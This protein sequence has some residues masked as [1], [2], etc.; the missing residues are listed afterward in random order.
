MKGTH[1]LST[2]LPLW[3]AIR[4]TAITA[5]TTGLL[6]A[7]A[8]TPAVPESSFTIQDWL[9][10]G[11][12]AAENQDWATAQTA[13]A[14]ALKA[15]LSNGY[16][17]TLNGLAYDQ[18][19]YDD[20]SQ[21]EFAQVAY[22]NAQDLAPGQYWVSLMQGFLALRRNEPA[23]AIPHF[24]RAAMDEE[25]QWEAA[26]GLGVAAYYTGDLMLAEASVREALRHQA[27][28]PEVIRLSAL[29]RAASGNEEALNEVGR[30]AK[31]TTD[32][33]DAAWLQQRVEHLLRN[34]LFQES[35]A[36]IALAQ[37][38]GGNAD[39]S[40]SANETENYAGLYENSPPQIS[41]DVTIILSSVSKSQ[42]RGINLL[43]ALSATYSLDRSYS[44][45]T[46]EQTGAAPFSSAVKT[47]TRNI[48]IPQINYNLNLFN[49]SGQYYSVLARPSLTAY[50]NETSDFFAGRTIN[51]SVNGI[52]SG[53]IIPIDIGVSLTVTPQSI[54]TDNTIIRV[55][56]NRSFLSANEIGQFRES[57]TTFKQ[58]VSAMADIKFGQTLILSALSETVRDESNSKVPLLGDVPILS[59]FTK[60][61]NVAEREESILILVTP[62]RPSVANLNIQALRS[63]ETKR[64][65]RFWESMAD[66]TS[67]VGD[68]IK[69]LEKMPIFREA[70]KA[71]ISYKLPEEKHI[72]KR[73][74]DSTYRLATSL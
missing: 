22:D 4:T 67:N 44:K 66:P 39:T 38:N 10:N 19:S 27:D 18:L 60:E 26:Y 74:L 41:V 71:D 64:L 31:L 69:R 40:V 56:A 16:L 7:C 50:L 12:K 8:Q 49:N 57:L 43:D 28:R 55:A 3:R 24:T 25:A 6:L 62:Q 47:I 70:Q 11:R 33:A 13:F 65:I 15:D 59:T 9:N 72:V 52:Q 1:L 51:V 53:N 29:V 68:I 20:I 14:N 61:K 42:R 35:E 54:T 37:Y 46:Q 21:A 23:A 30:Y 58:Q 48:G 34:T 17:Q 36:A 32:Q 63:D 45:T 73:A 5:A 2:P